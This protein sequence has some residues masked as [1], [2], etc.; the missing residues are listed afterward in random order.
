MTS[1]SVITS[2]KPVSNCEHAMYLESSLLQLRD[3]GLMSDVTIVC[4]SQTFK[5]HKIILVASSG[6]FYNI[7]TNK[8][9][10]DVKHLAMTDITPDIL[11]I[12]LDYIYTG[13]LNV[14]RFMKINQDALIRALDYLDMSDVYRHRL[15]LMMKSL[16]PN[17][18][19]ELWSLADF[20]QMK[21]MSNEIAKYIS[22][23]LEL[24]M[25]NRHFVNLTLPQLVAVLSSESLKTQSETMALEAI[26][27]WILH[28]IST[29][30][31]YAT[32]LL[33]VAKVTVSAKSKAI[34]FY[35]GELQNFIMAPN[36]RKSSSPNFKKEK[37]KKV[38]HKESSRSSQSSVTSCRSEKN[39]KTIRTWKKKPSKLEDLTLSKVEYTEREFEFNLQRGDY[40][41][42]EEIES[43]NGDDTYLYTTA[44]L[45]AERDIDTIQ[46][47]IS[48]I[49]PP[50]IKND[51]T[52]CGNGDELKSTFV[53][54]EPSNLCTEYLKTK[55]LP[56]N[57]VARELIKKFK[58]PIR[59]YSI[60][61]DPETPA[62]A[63]DTNHE[64]NNHISEERVQIMK[65]KSKLNLII[66]RIR[67]TLQ[68]NTVSQFPNAPSEDDSSECS[69]RSDATFVDNDVTKLTNTCEEYTTGP[70]SKY[71]KEVHKSPNII[72]NRIISNIMTN[73]NVNKAQ[74]YDGEE[75]SD[76]KL[77]LNI[78]ER[79]TRDKNP[80]S[81]TFRA[82]EKQT[83]NIQETEETNVRSCNSPRETPKSS[84][85]KNALVNL[86]RPI[87]T[88]NESLISPE[89]VRSRLEKFKRLM[90]TKCLNPVDVEKINLKGSRSFIISGNDVDP[91][92][93]IGDHCDF[94][95]DISE[96]DT[97]IE[98]NSTEDCLDTQ[99]EWFRTLSTIPEETSICDFTGSSHTELELRSVKSDSPLKFGE[100]CKANWNNLESKDNY[101]HEMDKPIYVNNSDLND[102]D[103]NLT[104][105][106]FECEIDN[107]MNDEDTILSN[108]QE[109]EQE[110]MTDTVVSNDF[111]K[112]ASSDHLNMQKLSWDSTNSISVDNE[113]ENIELTDGRSEFSPY[114]ASLASDKLRSAEGS[115][116]SDRYI[117]SNSISPLCKLKVSDDSESKVESSINSNFNCEDM[118]EST[119]SSST[120]TAVKDIT[121]NTFQ[122]GF[123]HL[124]LGELKINKINNIFEYGGYQCFAERSTLEELESP[125]A[126]SSDT[127]NITLENLIKPTHNKMKFMPHANDNWKMWKTKLEE[128]CKPS[129]RPIAKTNT[130]QEGKAIKYFTPNISVSPSLTE[131]STEA[132]KSS[133]DTDN[134]ELRNAL[135]RKFNLSPKTKSSKEINSSYSSGTTPELSFQVSTMSTVVVTPFSSQITIHEEIQESQATVEP[136][137][138]TF[139]TVD[140]SELAQKDSEVTNFSARTHVVSSNYHPGNYLPS[141]RE[142]LLRECSLRE[143]LLPKAESEKELHTDTKKEKNNLHET[144]S[145]LTTVSRDRSSVYEDSSYVSPRVKLALQNDTQYLDE[146]PLLILLATNKHNEA[147]QQV[148]CLRR[149]CWLTQRQLLMPPI[150]NNY[151]VGFFEG[152]VY[153]IGGLLN[154][155]FRKTNSVFIYRSREHMLVPASDLLVAR[156]G[157][158]V[159]NLN[160]KIYVA[161]GIGRYHKPIAQVERYDTKAD[162]WHLVAALRIARTNVCLVTSGKLLYAIGGTV[163]ADSVHEVVS[164]A[165]ESYDSEIDQWSLL[166]E[167]PSHFL[168]TNPLVTSVDSKLYAVRISKPDIVFR[169]HTRKNKWLPIQNTKLTAS[170]V[171]CILPGERKLYAVELAGKTIHSFDMHAFQ[172]EVETQFPSGL[173]WQAAAF[174]VGLLDE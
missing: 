119:K 74:R 131:D 54:H 109:Q 171:C 77:S 93:A 90:H 39:D 73:G 50:I 17:Y 112:N 96:A 167:L 33:S 168:M 6:Y 97:M 61:I 110:L 63:V 130:F 139:P 172:W 79:I 124:S 41:I 85:D 166:V 55:L 8:L 92:N 14:N 148:Y 30:E 28:D 126:R 60:Q 20:Y 144:S 145:S 86:K 135:Q 11:K 3:T 42:G 32:N 105:S 147:S 27:K 65:L 44:K 24:C 123:E 57:A 64:E 100:K 127:L 128:S 69:R 75:A 7:F 149:R 140:I 49:Y 163:S 76:M 99:P 10:K 84:E 25:D 94:L 83:G 141:L 51:E 70:Y 46:E 81:N 156:V 67:C 36:R 133:V 82:K 89:E 125:T 173:H 26:Q 37:G 34:A 115:I 104:D 120:G 117:S 129:P 95:S 1:R 114:W 169:F 137:E 152:N 111:L 45:K 160:K 108:V 91:V 161:G 150:E 164:K 13:L 22:Q 138:V 122:S 18:Y 56:P 143:T 88:S 116:D 62:S 103:K 40:Q 155:S 102:L 35:D 78:E 9:K 107:G 68:K 47:E 170:K 174:V 23:N 16:A 29:R 106:M 15:R 154:G 153:Y 158:G 132:T 159:A 165:C 66:N 48:D 121:D 146:G 87:A 72:K 4:G 5:A 53:N 113:Q 12:I 31:K 142:N 98:P 19:S 71:F 43:E 2:P 21:D 151:S 118:L 101:A 162:R 58:K 38:V 80:L 52:S 59:V 157:A 134:E 136:M